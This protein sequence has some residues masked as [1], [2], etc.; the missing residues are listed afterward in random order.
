MALRHDVRTL[1]NWRRSSIANTCGCRCIFICGLSDVL[2]NEYLFLFIFYGAPWYNV[3]VAVR[4][5][6]TVVLRQYWHYPE[7]DI[8]LH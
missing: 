4:S 1:A 2:I 7:N 8:F 6:I 3:A 5:S